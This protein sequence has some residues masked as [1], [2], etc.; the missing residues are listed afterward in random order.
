MSHFSDDSQRESLSSQDITRLVFSIMRINTSPFSSMKTLLSH[1][2]FDH[3]VDE[4]ARK[5]PEKLKK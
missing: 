4:L 1:P 3:L 2:R 5:N